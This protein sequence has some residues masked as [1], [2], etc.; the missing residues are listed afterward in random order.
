M[1][2]FLFSCFIKNL[3]SNIV[4]L[5]QKFK[6]IF[7][8]I[9]KTLMVSLPQINDFGNNPLPKM[10]NYFLFIEF[11]I[12]VIRIKQVALLVLFAIKFNVI[13]HHLLVN[14]NFFIL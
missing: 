14:L 9:L 10:Y 8:W 4:F 5:V 1:S 7:K 2:C 12:L 3:Q 6:G 13:P 11:I